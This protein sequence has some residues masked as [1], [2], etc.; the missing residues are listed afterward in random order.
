MNKCTN[1]SIYLFFV[2]VIMCI[3]TNSLNCMK[4][5]LF[6]ISLAMLMIAIE[7]V[8]CSY[9]KIKTYAFSS[10]LSATICLISWLTKVDF[11]N[12]QIITAFIFLSSSTLIL[13]TTVKRDKE[14]KLD[15]E[16]IDKLITQ[17]K[18]EMENQAQQIEAQVEFDKKKTK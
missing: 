7:D 10:Y 3:V 9:T 12:I 15:L 1:Y 16:Y 6:F 14:I 4:S 11:N 2:Q 18:L 13:L 17:L 5:I 8:L